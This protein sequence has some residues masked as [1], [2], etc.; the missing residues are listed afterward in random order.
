[1]SEARLF[2]ERFRGTLRG[3]DCNLVDATP[4]HIHDLETPAI[5][6]EG[7]RRLRHAAELPHHEPRQGMEAAVFRYVGEADRMLDLGQRQQT[8]DKPRAVLA[9]QALR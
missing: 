9:P 6:Y 4:I 3:T 8:V 1:M 2:D 5:P 7:V